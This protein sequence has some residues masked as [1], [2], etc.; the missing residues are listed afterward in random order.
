MLKKKNE[1]SFREHRLTEW[2]T[3]WD[4]VDVSVIYGLHLF[5]VG[6]LTNDVSHVAFI[7]T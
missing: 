2:S 4:E 5:L 6:R 3:R 7:N 1:E